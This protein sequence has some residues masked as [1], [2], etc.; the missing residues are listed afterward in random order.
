M[1]VFVYTNIFACMH[2]HIY[3]R[4]CVCMCVCTC[5]HSHTYNDVS[6]LNTDE[7]YIAEVSGKF[8]DMCT[9]LQ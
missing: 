2:A 4:I 3:A 7:L 6:V 5:I 1:C 8:Y 9:L